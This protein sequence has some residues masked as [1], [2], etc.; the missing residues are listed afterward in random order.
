MYDTAGGM[1]GPA[2][3]FKK[4]KLTEKQLTYFLLTNRNFCIKNNLCLHTL[5]FE[6]RLNLITKI[7]SAPENRIILIIQ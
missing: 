4:A 3:I 6:L 1:D 7:R 5:H 2:V